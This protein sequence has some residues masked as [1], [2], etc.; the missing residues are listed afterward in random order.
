MLKVLFVCIENSCRSQM[1]E[2]FF[3]S[4]TDKAS[5]SSAGTNPSNKVDSGAVESLNEVGID[6]SDQKPKLLSLKM[7]DEFDYIVTM[8]CMLGCPI[9]PKEKTIVW[10][11]EDPKGKTVAEFAR[12]RDEIKAEVG[13]L[14]RQLSL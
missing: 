9:T 3:N 13:K 1:A 2:A 5:A 7:N 11:I 10:D 14:I 8:G 4:L 6:I 12:I